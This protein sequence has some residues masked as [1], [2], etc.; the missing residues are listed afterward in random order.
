MINNLSAGTY[1]VDV[2]DANGC[3]VSQSVTLTD[4]GLPTAFAVATEASC[5]QTNGQATVTA[6]NGTPPYSFSWSDGI[7]STDSIAINLAAQEYTITVT[8]GN[9]CEFVTT[10][11]VQNADGPSVDLTAENANC[12]NADG[13]ATA[14]VTGGELPYDY[15]WSLSLIHI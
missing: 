15:I 12:G 1:S 10:V 11:T 2:T 6:N 13:V 14:L 5:G 7:T 3:A 9:D 8:D 4:N